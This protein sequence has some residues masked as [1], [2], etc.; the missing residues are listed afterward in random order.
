MTIDNDTAREYAQL[1]TGNA[2]PFST[3][4]LMLGTQL[5][6]RIDNGLRFDLH[7]SPHR[8]TLCDLIYNVGEDLFELHFYRG[9]RKVESLT[10]LFADQLQEV[11]ERHTQLR[12]SVPRICGINA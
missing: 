6:L 1:L 12:L 7:G 5:I 11:F 3:L 10:G 8:L 2:R 4:R 9:G